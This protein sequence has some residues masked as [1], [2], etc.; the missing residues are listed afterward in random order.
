MRSLTPRARSHRRAV[1]GEEPDER[2]QTARDLKLELEWIATGGVRT[3][4]ARPAHTSPLYPSASSRRRHSGDGRRR[5]VRLQPIAS[6]AAP[7]DPIHPRLQLVRSSRAVW[8]GTRL[9]ISPD[10]RQIAFVATTGG[11]DRLCGCNHSIH[12]PHDCLLMEL[13]RRSGPPTAGSSVSSLPVKDSSRRSTSQAG[14]RCDLSSRRVHPLCLASQRHDSVCSGRY[15][16]LPRVGRRRHADSSDPP[17]LCR[18][19]INHLWPAWLPDGKYFL[20]TATSLDA[21]GR[22]APR[23]VY[24]R[25]VDSASRSS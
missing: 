20:Y 17:R 1:H 10:G 11:V 13:S 2:W 22:R 6:A 4:T 9:A 25:A 3:T 7:G 23:T 12:S 8:T 19:E 18:R 5:G 21:I 15:G 16:N 24:V 14:P